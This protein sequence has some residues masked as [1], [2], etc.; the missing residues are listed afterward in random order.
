MRCEVRGEDGHPTLAG[1]ANHDEWVLPDCDE[2]LGIS[3]GSG[4]VVPEDDR[5][6]AKIRDGGV[7]GDAGGLDPLRHL[8]PVIT[9]EDRDRQDVGGMHLVDGRQPIR[10]K[11]E[12]RGHAGAVLGHGLGRIGRSR[13]AIQARIVAAVTRRKKAQGSIF[14]L[15]IR[16][17][18]H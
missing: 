13:A 15:Q 1:L 14:M 18:S 9:R 16:R 11:A 3:L 17:A 7:I 12:R 5:P 4:L 6:L 2:D 10:T 8:D